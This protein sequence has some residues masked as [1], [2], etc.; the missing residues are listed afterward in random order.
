MKSR[1]IEISQEN[2]SLSS[3]IVS[4][5]Q[6]MNYFLHQGPWKKRWIVNIRGYLMKCS[7][8]WRIIE[9]ISEPNF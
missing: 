7:Y 1:V 8:E 6:M 4:T 3:S 2:K 5:Q 9:A